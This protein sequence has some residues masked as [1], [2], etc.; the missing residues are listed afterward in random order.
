MTRASFVGTEWHKLVVH[1][2]G[3]R[4][5]VSYT[6]NE[7]YKELREPRRFGAWQSAAD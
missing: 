4:A 6:E 1:V 7:W 3:E 5:D 2:V